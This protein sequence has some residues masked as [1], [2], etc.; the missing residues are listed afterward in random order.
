MSNYYP[1]KFVIVKV[2]SPDYGTLYR[3]LASW[4]GGYTGSNS[5]KLSSGITKIT[6]TDTGY[7]FLNHSGSVYFGSKEIYGMSSYTMS[8]Y[9]GFV[10]QLK[11]AGEG[12]SIEVIDEE[13]I[14]TLEV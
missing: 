12:H 1:D 9:S 10:D 3:V 13:A 6:K 5:W 14:D 7:E 4:Y 11:E 8:I 2:T